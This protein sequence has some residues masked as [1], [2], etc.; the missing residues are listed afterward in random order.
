[1]KIFC[2]YFFKTMITL[3]S[4]LNS[5]F[6]WPIYKYITMIDT[7]SYFILIDRISYIIL[8]DKRWFSWEA[9]TVQGAPSLPA[10]SHRF[11]QTPRQSPRNIQEPQ[12]GGQLATQSHPCNPDR[13]WAGAQRC[14]PWQPPSHRLSPPVCLPLQS[15]EHTSLTFVHPSCPPRQ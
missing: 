1:M 4:H 5:F 2:L 10:E 3:H 15:I 6:V 14:R 9:F 12:L 8:L 13:S 7:I 11:D